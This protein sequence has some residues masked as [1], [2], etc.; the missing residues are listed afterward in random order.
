MW[1]RNSPVAVAHRRVRPVRR[2]HGAPDVADLAEQQ[3]R[4][5]RSAA[6]VPAARTA[7]TS[8]SDGRQPAARRDDRQ[9]VD[10]VHADPRRRR[11]TACSVQ[12]SISGGIIARHSSSSAR[13]SSSG[14]LQQ[15]RTI[16]NERPRSASG[17]SGAGGTF[18]S[19]TA[20][21]SSSGTSAT[22][23][24]HRSTHLG[25]GIRRVVQVAGVDV[26]DGEQLDLHVRHDAAGAPAAAAQGAEQLRV[27]VAARPHELSVGRDDLE[28]A[29]GVA[30]RAVA[31]GQPAE[32]AA[33]RVADRADRRRRA[34]Q[35]RQ[36]WTWAAASTG[37][38]V[39]PAPTQAVRSSGS[40]TTSC[41]R[42]VTS[43]TPS[44]G[45]DHAVAGRL[46]AQ[47]APESRRRR[48]RWR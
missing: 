6:N 13:P 18:I 15:P 19:T 16:V 38:H 33:E 9:R 12:A 11:R 45:H 47:A 35:R 1:S 30:R 21:V 3:R 46:D 14:P 20:D 41:R 31:A 8:A 5:R 26:G 43:S 32:P 34:D 25:R 22:H 29:H 42:A 36:P 48:R 17:T 39:Q 37:P 23:A 27:L 28:R 44:T 4:R 10:R 40:T 2:G 24:D 7:P